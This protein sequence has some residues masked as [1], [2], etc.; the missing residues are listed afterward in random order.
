[1]TFENTGSVGIYVTTLELFATPA[2]IVK[3]LYV[4][5]QDDT[6]VS[7][8]DERPVVIENNFISKEDEAYSKAHIMLNDYA[9]Y[10]GIKVLDA[11]GNMALQINDCIDLTLPLEAVATYIIY[12]MSCSISAGKFRQVIT[13]KQ[14]D[15]QHYFT[16]GVSS[17][18]GTDLIAP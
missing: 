10:G 3:E 16:I 15:P 7:K 12:K 13:A 11:K 6:S 5:E 18:G 1:M 9:E 4:R 17:I 14:R 2:K 8:Y